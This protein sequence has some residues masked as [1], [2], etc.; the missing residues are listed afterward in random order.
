MHVI[1]LEDFDMEIT[2]NHKQQLRHIRLNWSMVRWITP[3]LIGYI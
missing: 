1:I 3:K 2:N